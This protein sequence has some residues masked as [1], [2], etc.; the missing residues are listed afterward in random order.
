MKE[1]GKRGEGERR[2]RSWVSYIGGGSRS[3]VGGVSPRQQKPA[4][5]APRLQLG[6]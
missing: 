1:T 4:P 2:S 5:N 6:L 3:G